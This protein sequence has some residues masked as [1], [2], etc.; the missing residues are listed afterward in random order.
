LISF[1]RN[2]LN[3]DLND[4]TKIEKLREKVVSTQ[5]VINK[6]W[7]LEKITALEQKPKYRN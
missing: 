5:G 1:T 7:I 3:L 6:T 2:L 4:R